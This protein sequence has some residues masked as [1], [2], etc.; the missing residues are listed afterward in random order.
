M[1]SILLESN[2]YQQL[3]IS[4]LMNRCLEY[5]YQNLSSNSMNELQRYF[6]EFCSYCKDNSINSLKK[7]TSEFLKDYGNYLP[8]ISL[9]S[10]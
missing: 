10:V 5:E 7:I 4:T 6:T 8:P 2:N 3:D 9:E 1:H